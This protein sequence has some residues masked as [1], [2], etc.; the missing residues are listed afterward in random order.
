V[1]AYQT[2]SQTVPNGI[3]VDFDVTYAEWASARAEATREQSE[4][5]KRG[6]GEPLSVL[7][8]ET[9]AWAAQLPSDVQPHELMRS[10]ARIANRLAGGWSEPDATLAYFQQLLMTQ[11]PNRKGFPVQVR[12]ELILLCRCYVDLHGRGETTR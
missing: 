2:P 11:R 9:V 6:V 4:K 10:F 8:P 5:R 12:R 7:L 3:H 1:N